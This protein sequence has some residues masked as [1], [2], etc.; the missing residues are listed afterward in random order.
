[1]STLRDDIETRVLTFGHHADETEAYKICT[2]E[3]I[4][5]IEKRIVDELK[6]KHPKNLYGAYNTGLDDVMEMLK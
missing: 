5:L 4:K 6:T 2:N 1:M 3:I